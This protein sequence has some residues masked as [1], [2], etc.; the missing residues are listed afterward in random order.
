MKT[1]FYFYTDPAHGWLEVPRG[2]LAELGISERVSRY[3][4]QRGEQVYLEEDCD[5]SIFRRA[6]MAAGREFT[7]ADIHT[8]GEVF[9]SLAATLHRRRIR[10]GL[11]NGRL[12]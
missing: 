5:Y 7:T 3:S 4:Y 9:R 6:M 2:L 11:D 12:K 8:D 1:E 10:E